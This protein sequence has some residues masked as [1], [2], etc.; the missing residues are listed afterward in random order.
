MKHGTIKLNS[1]VR[2]ESEAQS[3]IFSGNINLLRGKKLTIL[4]KMRGA[5]IRKLY[6]SVPFSV[7]MIAN[8]IG[9]QPLNIDNNTFVLPLAD[10]SLSFHADHFLEVSVEGLSATDQYQLYTVDSAIDANSRSHI[11]LLEVDNE[12]LSVR[13]NVG[14]EDLLFLA[15]VEDFFV[16]IELVYPTKTIVIGLNEL[17]AIMNESMPYAFYDGEGFEAL[18]ELSFSLIPLDGV[19]SYKINKNKG[20]SAFIYN[21]YK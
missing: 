10:G 3:I 5:P 2:I 6:D 11:E 17:H 20:E 19:V 18:P 4:E 14:Q 21:I 7:V 8:T 9:E 15:G 12:S 1:S 13:N 16:D